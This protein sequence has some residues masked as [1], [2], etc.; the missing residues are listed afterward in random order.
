LDRSYDLLL[1]ETIYLYD[2]VYVHCV[3]LM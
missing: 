3:A 1:V 2:V